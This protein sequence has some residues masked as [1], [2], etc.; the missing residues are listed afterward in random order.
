MKQ[1]GVST[2][3]NSLSLALFE[4]G[5]ICASVTL[6]SRRK[7]GELL[8]SAIQNLLAQMNWQPTDIEEIYVD[9]GPGSYTGLRVGVTMAKTWE[10]A[11]SVKIYQLSSLALFVAN[12]LESPHENQLIV[13]LIDSRRNTAYAGI[14]QIVDQQV[15]ELVGDQHVHWTDFMAEIH[16]YQQEFPGIIFVGEKIDEFVHQYQMSFPEVVVNSVQGWHS[17]PKVEA[18]FQ[19][20][21]I[22]VTDGDLL[23]PNYGLETL[24]V[25][26]W[27]QR[28]SIDLDNQKEE[29]YVDRY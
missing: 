18:L 17:L 13:P 15:V 29:S 23:V 5:Q 14:Y 21:R 22:K 2:S 9:V 20:P 7:H 16:H 27:A 25:R 1:L 6:I 12:L 28:E 24:A 10:L 19:T 26:Q 8:L 11:Q 3:T 4:S